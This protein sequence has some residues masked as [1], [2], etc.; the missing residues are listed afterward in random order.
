MLTTST[1]PIALPQF[2]VQCTRHP[3]LTRWKLFWTI[4]QLQWVDIIW[5]TPQVA[6]EKEVCAICATT[7]A[8]W[9]RQLHNMVWRFFLT[10]SRDL[11]IKVF[12]L[13]PVEGL[14]PTSL[15]AH[16]GSVLYHISQRI[17]RPYILW[18]RMEYDSNGSIS[19]GY[20]KV[21]NLSMRYWD[22]EMSEDEG[23][24]DQST[25]AYR[26]PIFIQTGLEYH[27]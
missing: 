15:A 2:Q 13:N 24:E 11:T 9:R 5:K 3:A 4:L 25:I 6:K 18:A 8:L 1:E 26:Q 27:C 22:D 23:E 10:G 7:K 19:G 14:V 12:S 17:R 16:K 20:G 21:L